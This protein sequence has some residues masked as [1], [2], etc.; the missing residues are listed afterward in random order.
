VEW[1][2]LPSSPPLS[3]GLC[4]VKISAKKLFLINF[5]FAIL[6]RKKQK[7]KKIQETFGTIQHLWKTIYLTVYRKTPDTSACQWAIQY[8]WA[9]ICKRLWS[10]AQSR[11]SAKL[12][13]SRRNWD[14]PN[15]SPAG[16][17]P[18][19][20]WRERG[21]ESPNSDEGT[22]TVVLYMYMYFVEPRNRFRQAGNWF[23]GYLKGLLIRALVESIEFEIF[24]N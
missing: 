21:W 20:L 12:F 3:S 5:Y 14:S 24:A 10:P 11:Q 9:L 13:S 15:P 22:H 19:P 8:I 7:K 17:F 2:P 4:F 23:L 6:G 1:T 16:E 18:P